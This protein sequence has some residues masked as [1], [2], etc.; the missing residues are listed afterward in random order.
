MQALAVE[1]D[2]KFGLLR[3]DGTTVARM[4]YSVESS[5]ISRKIQTDSRT[6]HLDILIDNDVAVFFLD[7]REALSTRIYRMPGK[8]WGIYV[9]DGEAVFANLT[10]RQLKE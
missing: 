5:R 3:Y 9:S 10:M 4:R 7:H 2:M 8:P 6:Y 1:L